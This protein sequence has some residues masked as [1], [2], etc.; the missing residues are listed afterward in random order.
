MGGG[1]ITRSRRPDELVVVAVWERRRQCRDG[2]AMDHISGRFY[3]FGM[4]MTFVHVPPSAPR[5]ETPA[6]RL[7]RVR[8]EAE[9]IAVGHADIDAGLGI[10][11]SDLEAWLDR[12]DQGEIAPPPVPS[13]RPAR[14]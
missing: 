1:G 11:E 14:S 6:E 5:P 7:R 12:L 13:N 10:D 3:A 2:F 4:T 8:R 9:V